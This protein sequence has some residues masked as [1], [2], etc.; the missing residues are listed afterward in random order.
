MTI[1][2]NNQE[3]V[4]MTTTEIPYHSDLTIEKLCYFLDISP[5]ATILI[6]SMQFMLNTAERLNEFLNRSTFAKHPLSLLTKMRKEDI[7]AHGYKDKTTFVYDYYR[8]KK[9]AFEKLFQ[10]EALQW[11]MDKYRTGILNAFTIATLSKVS[12]HT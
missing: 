10:E 2:L 9:M 8:N 4:T 11:K 1:T 5:K 6:N 3:V 7:D 12:I